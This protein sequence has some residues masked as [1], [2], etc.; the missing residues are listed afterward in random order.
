MV[1]FYKYL[2]RCEGELVWKGRADEEEFRE[3]NGSQRGSERGGVGWDEE[4]KG[5]E[6]GKG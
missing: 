4:V 2:L 3:K 6:Y 5:M 1:L